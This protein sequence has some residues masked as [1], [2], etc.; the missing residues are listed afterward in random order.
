MHEKERPVGVAGDQRIGARSAS[1][2]CRFSVFAAGDRHIEQEHRDFFGREP[3][4]AFQ[5]AAAGI[6]Q[7]RDGSLPC[8][9]DRRR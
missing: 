3:S 5:Q 6:G 1:A 7:L 9:G 8:D 2:S 4:E